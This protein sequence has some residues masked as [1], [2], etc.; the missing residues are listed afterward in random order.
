MM[1]KSELDCGEV[2]GGFD[3]D[4][5]QLDGRKNNGRVPVSINTSA[6]KFERSWVR[7]REV[8]LT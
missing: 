5:M 3:R 8:Q 6:Q 4:A 7:H 1:E 2:K